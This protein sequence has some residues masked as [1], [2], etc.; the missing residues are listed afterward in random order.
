MKLTVNLT[1]FEWNQCYVSFACK[2]CHVRRGLYPK[3]WRTTLILTFIQL[4]CISADIKY[5]D[6]VLIILMVSWH[7]LFLWYIVTTLIKYI[8]QL[9]QIKSQLSWT[10]VSTIF[11]HYYGLSINNITCQGGSIRQKLIFD[12]IGED[13]WQLILHLLSTWLTADIWQLM[14]H[15]LT[16]WLTTDIWQLCLVCWLLDLLTFQF[17]WLLID[18]HDGFFLNMK[19][20][21]KCVF[22]S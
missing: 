4:I 21:G 14:P 7:D 20:D 12:I 6:R 22:K 5:P 8:A 11:S 3:I 13:I 9:S 18:G 15:L 16:T 10:E 1:K 17:T 19:L 2:I